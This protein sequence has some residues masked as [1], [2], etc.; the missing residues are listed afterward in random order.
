[1]LLAPHNRYFSNNKHTLLYP[2]HA[3]FLHQTNN[4]DQLDELNVY[5][6]LAFYAM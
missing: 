4:S 1:M 3:I 2:F 5:M 6:Y